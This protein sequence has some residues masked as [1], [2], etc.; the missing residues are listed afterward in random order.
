MASGA[1]SA[2]PGELFYWRIGAFK[3]LYLP[4]HC[5]RS[6]RDQAFECCSS[7]VLWRWLI[8][9][10]EKLCFSGHDLQSV[11]FFWA[12]LY[13]EMPAWLSHCKHH[14]HTHTHFL[15]AFP[16]NLLLEQFYG[17]FWYWPKENTDL[18]L[19]FVLMGLKILWHIWSTCFYLK[20]THFKI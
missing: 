1:G 8:W 9:Y 11:S 18:S 20:S 5:L 10:S 12:R 6:C 4:S 19:K 17:K 16:L 15:K 7:T 14:T 13:F 3:V 2:S